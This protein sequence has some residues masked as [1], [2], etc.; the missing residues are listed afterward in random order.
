MAQ[1]FHQY[2]S[3]LCFEERESLRKQWP[4]DSI[5]IG[6]KVKTKGYTSSAYIALCQTGSGRTVIVKIGGSRPT[7]QAN[8]LSMLKRYDFA[9]SPSIY[10][11]YFIIDYNVLVMELMPG[12]S[13]SERTWWNLCDEGRENFRKQFLHVMSRFRDIK[14]DCLPGANDCGLHRHNTEQAFA[15]AV[16]ISLEQADISPSRGVTPDDIEYGRL[17]VRDYLNDSARKLV[18]FVPTHGE[19]RPRNILVDA[20]GN[21]SSLLDFSNGGFLPE[22]C[23]LGFAFD[24]APWDRWWDI[25]MV[26]T[27]EALSPDY[28]RNHPMVLFLRTEIQI[29]DDNSPYAWTRDHRFGR[30]IED[31]LKTRNKFMVPRTL[32][33]VCT[34]L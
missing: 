9:Y 18:R 31:W 29:T 8:F 17:L 32:K 4:R 1:M 34:L 33:S 28:G 20:N 30:G 7:N 16:L 10:G 23:E 22:Y 11:F 13:L 27:L 2:I 19:L 15:N 24:I 25:V 14:C 26:E 12:T 3:P 5:A 21:I 6:D